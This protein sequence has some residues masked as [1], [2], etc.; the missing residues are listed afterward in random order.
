MPEKKF[1]DGLYFE[2]RDNA[3][4]FVVG[5]A[6]IKVEKFIQFLK[7]NV[8]GGGYV[9]IN[10]LK[11]REAGKYYCELDTWTPKTEKSTMTSPSEDYPEGI[12]T[13]EIP[14]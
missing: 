9:N 4:D 8:N 6:S 5:R 7:D 13:E 3:P 10:I 2:R 11:A 14:F 1:T 12:D